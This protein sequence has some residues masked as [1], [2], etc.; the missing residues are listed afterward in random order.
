LPCAVQAI[1]K[2][3]RAFLL[4]GSDHALGG[5]CKVAWPTAQQHADRV[6]WVVLAWSIWHRVEAAMGM[7]SEKW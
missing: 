3:R 4:T 2:H 6:T 5:H 1:D 7:D